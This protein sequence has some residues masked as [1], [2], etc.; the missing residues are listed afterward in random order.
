M[1]VY[2]RGARCAARV[3]AGVTVCYQPQLDAVAAACG[4]IDAVNAQVLIAMLREPATE[5]LL[6]VPTAQLD[7]YAVLVNVLREYSGFSER[8]REPNGATACKVVASATNEA[9]YKASEGTTIRRSQD[10]SMPKSDALVAQPEQP[11]Y[12]NKMT[13]NTS[14]AERFGSNSTTV[15]AT[16]SSREDRSSGTTPGSAAR[17]CRRTSIWAASVTPVMQLEKANSAW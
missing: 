12:R 11:Q 17:R 16:R 3:F 5:L 6:H 2:L 15:A 4:W 14:S 9:K 7:T 13:S 10:V 8:L 1:A